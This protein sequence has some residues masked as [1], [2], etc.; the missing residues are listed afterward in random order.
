M[1]KKIILALITALVI[2]GGIYC[3]TSQNKIASVASD[4]HTAQINT[5]HMMTTPTSAILA[6]T[7]VIVKNTSFKSG[8][9]LLSFELYGKDGDAWSDKALKISHEKKMHF[10][11]VSSDFSDYQ[12]VHPEFKNKLWQ[13]QVALKNNMA[14]Q[15]YVDIDSEEDGAEV[16]RV[17]MTVGTSQAA[18]KVSQKETTL[19]KSGIEVQMNAESGF[20]TGK[21]NPVIFTLSKG[22]K[23]IIPE[24]YLGAKGHVVALGDDPNTFVHGHPDD[25]GDSEIHFAFSFEKSGT[26]TL[27]AQFQINGVVTTHPFTI[28]VGNTN[29]AMNESKAH[30]D[31]VPHN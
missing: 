28:S 21:E 27:F 24:Y 4:G 9:Q 1:N 23:T 26:Y 12:H 18:S 16:L 5:D 17:P 15:A 20:V 30:T 11:V 2:G 7:R 25:H 13:V 6:G 22:G 8:S 31:S 29:G 14:Y 10:I 19:T 3:V